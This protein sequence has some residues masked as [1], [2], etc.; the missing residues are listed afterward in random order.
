MH[1]EHW[2]AGA[3]AGVGLWPFHFFCLLLIGLLIGGVIYW[4]NHKGRRLGR[5]PAGMPRSEPASPA[6]PDAMEVLRQ[7]YARGEID[8]TSFEQ[9][10]ERLESSA[11][12]R[13]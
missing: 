3:A 2:E 7:R 11:R 13:D 6:G 10:R 9:M 5:F 8:A 4:L 1:W 12:P